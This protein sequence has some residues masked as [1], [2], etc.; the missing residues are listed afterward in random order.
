MP[1]LPSGQWTHLA[2]S[3]DNNIP[4]FK[5]YRNG[6]LVATTATTASSVNAP[7]MAIGVS[8]TALVEE[9]YVWNR[10]LNEAEVARL[11]SISNAG[12]SHPWNDG[13]SFM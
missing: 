4:A 7:D 2:L 12:M 8:L 9:A 13:K 6:V 11:Y 5:S 1:S 3:H 10:A